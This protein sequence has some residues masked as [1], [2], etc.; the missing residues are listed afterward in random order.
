MAYVIILCLTSASLS[1]LYNLFLFEKQQKS[2]MLK[3]L[4]ITIRI[5]IKTALEPNTMSIICGLFID[6]VSLAF[7]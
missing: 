3:I 5:T 2:L 7:H 1:T 4:N 6:S